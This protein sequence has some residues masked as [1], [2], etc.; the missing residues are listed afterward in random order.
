MASYRCAQLT[1]RVPGWILEDDGKL[2]RYSLCAA[3]RLDRLPP[4]SLPI[5]NGGGPQS[6]GD[7][8]DNVN[9][10]KNGGVGALG[11]VCDSPPL[12][13]IRCLCHALF[14]ARPRLLHRV[15]DRLA[16]RTPLPAPSAGLGSS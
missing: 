10:Y 3:V 6:A 15:H 13:A 4:K 11:Q 1:A 5:L 7:N 2:H 8:V 12:R 9:I 14:R 16:L